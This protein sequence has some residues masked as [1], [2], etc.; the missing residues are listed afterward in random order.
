MVESNN[1]EAF[2]ID[3]IFDII[4]NSAAV[5]TDP[6]PKPALPHERIVLL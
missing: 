5:V 6:I 2:L 1:P 4:G 3:L